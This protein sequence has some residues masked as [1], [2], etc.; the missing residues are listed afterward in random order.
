MGGRAFANRMRA[1]GQAIP[2]TDISPL[3][4][5]ILRRM[6]WMGRNGGGNGSYLMADSEGYVY[7][8][9]ADSGVCERMVN[10]LWRMVVGRYACV[11]DEQI[12]EDLISHLVDIGYIKE[13]AIYQAVREVEG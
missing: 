10:E 12:R 5:E 8:L 1:I 11:S 7:L 2:G 3:I 9:R 6:R 4:T 13:T